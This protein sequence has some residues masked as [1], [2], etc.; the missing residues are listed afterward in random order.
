MSFLKEIR[1]HLKAFDS[2]AKADIEKFIQLLEEIYSAHHVVALGQAPVSSVPPTRPDSAVPASTTGSISP[3]QQ[4]VIAAAT[5][6]PAP[7]PVSVAPVAAP[8]AVTIT[9]TEPTVITPT[10]IT[11]IASPTATTVSA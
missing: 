5:A 8:V 1:T 11:P 3:I 4:Q 10:S 6:A 7:A 2:T 9:T